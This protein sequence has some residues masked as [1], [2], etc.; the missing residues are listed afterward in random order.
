MGSTPVDRNT[1]IVHY[2]FAKSPALRRYLGTKDVYERFAVGLPNADALNKLL[3]EI[4]RLQSQLGEPTQEQRLAGKAALDRICALCGPPMIPTTEVLVSDG[5]QSAPQSTIHSS[6]TATSLIETTRSTE[7][8]PT[9]LGSEALSMR[10]PDVLRSDLAYTLKANVPKPSRRWPCDAG[11]Y[12]VFDTQDDLNHHKHNMHSARLWTCPLCQ[13]EFTELPP[14]RDHVEICDHREAKSSRIQDATCHTPKPCGYCERDAAQCHAQ[15]GLDGHSAEYMPAGAW[16]LS[17]FDRELSAVAIPEASSIS[18]LSKA[19]TEPTQRVACI[20]LLDFLALW[21]GNG[22]EADTDFDLDRDV[23]LDSWEYG[24]VS[25]LINHIYAWLNKNGRKIGWACTEGEQQAG[26]NGSSSL[27][28]SYPNASHPSSRKRAH[29]ERYTV[30]PS[31]S[32]GN[33]EERRERKMPKFVGIPADPNNKKRTFAC[34]HWQVS[35]EWRDARC[36]NGKQGWEK[37]SW[38]RGVRI[39]LRFLFAVLVYD[40]DWKI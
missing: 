26:A 1:W 11:C 7:T 30:P 3:H 33:S 9:S 39:A 28:P 36:T 4:H 13:Q 22:S 18:P 40:V 35:A 23:F 21:P 38:L 14:F 24:I 31:E 27:E 5:P 6:T 15:W 12:A 32:S 19:S 37:L 8:A 10:S 16:D 34:P 20:S 17:V 2:A 29:R 25:T